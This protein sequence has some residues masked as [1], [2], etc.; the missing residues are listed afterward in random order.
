MMAAHDREKVALLLERGADSGS[1]N[2][3]HHTALM[4]AA[5][6]RGTTAI[7]R[8]LLD[9]GAA[10]GAPPNQPPGQTVSP[11]LYAVWSGDTDKVALLLDK[12]A[13]VDAKVSI[14]GGIFTARPIQIAIFQRDVPMLRLLAGRGASTSALSEG[15]IGL[16]TDAVFSNDPDVVSAV[17]AL[18]ADVNQVDEHGETPL[19]H[20]ASIDYGDS[21]VIE[22]LLAAGARR[23]VAAPDKRTARDMARGYGHAEHLRRLE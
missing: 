2:A 16:V 9:R 18:G 20:A 22:V 1:V 13:E 4:V 15:G 12:G 5:N 6:H 21:R 11:L 10:G 8:M 7:V 14:G 17:L 23:D 3:L 19:M